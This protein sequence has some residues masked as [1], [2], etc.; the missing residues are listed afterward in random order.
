VFAGEAEVHLGQVLRD[1]CAGQLKPLYNF[2]N[3]L[4]GIDGAPIPLLKRDRVKRISGTVTSFDAGRAAPYQCSVLHHH[5]CAGAQIARVAPG[6]TSS[7]SF[8]PTWRRAPPVLITDDN[9]AR[10]KDWEIILDR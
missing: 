1:A 7:R 2:M 4:P 6:R 8:A 5:Q 9:F 10:N 3:D